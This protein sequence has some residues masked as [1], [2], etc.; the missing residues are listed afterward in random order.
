[1]PKKLDLLEQKFR[2]LLVISQAEY[3]ISPRGHHRIRWNC[4]CD[5]GKIVTVNAQ[6][7]LLGKTTSCGCGRFTEKNIVGQIFGKLK[8]LRKGTPYIDKRG[9]SQTRWI[10]KCV[11]GN[12]TIAL[13]S[14]LR[15]GK[16]RSCGCGIIESSIAIKLKEYLQ[17]KYE[18]ISEYKINGYGLQYAPYDIY[19]PKYKAFIEVQGLQHYDPDNWFN[20]KAGYSRR[21]YIDNLKKEF[22]T[23]NGIFIEIDLRSIKTIKQAILHVEMSIAHI[24]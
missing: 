12:E 3:Y 4:L 20:L 7:L 1:M 2:K 19:I 10:C 24:Q 18:S 22:A 8:V 16:H 17:Q 23:A 15:L 6:E 11:C 5:C 14:A 21:L 9:R 13:S